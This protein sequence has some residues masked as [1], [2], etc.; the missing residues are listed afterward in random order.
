MVTNRLGGDTETGAGSFALKYSSQTWSTSQGSV[1]MRTESS[2]KIGSGWLLPH[3]R[4]EYQRNVEEGQQATMV[5]ADQTNGPKYNFYPATINT[6]SLAVGLGSDFELRRGLK[7]GIDYQSLRS[8]GSAS[9]AGTEKSHAITVKV[10]KE[11]G[12]GK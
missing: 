4:I 5:Y 1:G 8:V 2:H 12:G 7:F 3:A 10:S 9:T 6:N 11:L